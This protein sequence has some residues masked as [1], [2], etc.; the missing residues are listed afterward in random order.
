DGAGNFIDG[1]FV[2]LGIKGQA[3][4]VEFDARV[5][6]FVHGQI[7]VAC[8]S[9]KNGQRGKDRGKQV[10]GFAV[11]GCVT[12]VGALG[13]SILYQ[14]IGGVEFCSPEIELQGARQ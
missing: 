7:N 6:D 5:N 14:Q 9:F 10:G 8:S 4:V 12:L 2:A 1:Q 11:S 13:S 3:H